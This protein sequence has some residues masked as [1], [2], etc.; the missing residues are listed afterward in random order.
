MSLAA[1]HSVVEPAELA[2][3]EVG[4]V[5]VWYI[6]RDGTQPRSVLLHRVRGCSVDKELSIIGTALKI[7]PPFF[8]PS[9]PIWRS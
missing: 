7:L 2:Y 5:K 9:N 8:H 1:S 6:H 4:V 3:L